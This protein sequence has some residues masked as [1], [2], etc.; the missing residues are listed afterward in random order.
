MVA[1]IAALL[2]LGGCRSDLNIAPEAYN[3][4]T[5]TES[6]LENAYLIVAETPGAGW[7]VEIDATRR[8]ADGT[9]VF[10]TLR[11]PIPV[12][13]YAVEPVRQ[14]SLTRATTERP[15]RIFARVMD[16]AS[17]EDRAYRQVR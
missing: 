3:G 11:R 12:A 6:T 15:L 13:V 1:F 14:Q 2:A 16:Y 9:D 5:L 8:S 17:T 10:V 4:P 7:G